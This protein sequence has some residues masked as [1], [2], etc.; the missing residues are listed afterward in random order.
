MAR[1]FTKRLKRDWLSALRSGEYEQGT[2]TLCAV[3]PAGAKY[4]C[5]GVLFEV[6]HGPDAWA[7]A[8]PGQGKFGIL[9]AHGD[10]SY[11][12]D[13]LLGYT[14]SRELAHLNDIGRTFDEI[15]DYVE[16]MW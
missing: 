13:E 1:Q 3:G 7:D 9:A 16:G 14:R 8:W 4:C 12:G 15:A 10:A 11:F 2:D 5:L 6:V